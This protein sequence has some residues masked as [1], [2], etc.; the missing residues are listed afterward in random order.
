MDENKRRIFGEK[1]MM[2]LVKA[3]EETFA[4]AAKLSKQCTLKMK[5]GK[6]V[7]H[8]ISRTLRKKDFKEL[9]VAVLDNRVVGGIKVED[10]SI[11][12]EEW[13]GK[14]EDGSIYLSK[15]FVDPK[16][17]RTGIGTKIVQAIKVLFEGRD[18]YLDVMFKP[19]K[20]LPCI[21]L[22]EKHGFKQI[23]LKDWYDVKRKQN[24]TWALYKF[25]AKN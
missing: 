23:G 13:F 6:I 20:N 18:I 5:N 14:L 12:D 16:Y 2:E 3:N 4:E 9:Y 10:L 25:S 24:F 15:L 19:E 7:K 8:G 22:F 11:S 17:F 1:D 21:N